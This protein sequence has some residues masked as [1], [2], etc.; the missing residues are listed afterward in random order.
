MEQKNHYSEKESK[1]LN[2]A[3]ADYINLEKCNLKNI[4]EILCTFITI[5]LSKLPAVL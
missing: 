3:R 5:R 4:L 2:K 1:Y